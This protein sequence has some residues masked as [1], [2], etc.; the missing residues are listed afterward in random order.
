MRAI[1]SNLLNHGHAACDLFLQLHADLVKLEFGH[2]DADGD[3][4]MYG[5][6]MGASLVTAASIKQVDHFLNK[7]CAAGA[8]STAFV[9]IV[10]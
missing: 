6:D 7:V 9:L 10:G 8:F 2:Y 4:L 5:V 3:G 1:P